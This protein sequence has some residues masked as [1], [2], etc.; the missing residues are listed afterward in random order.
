MALADLREFIDSPKLTLPIG[1]RSYNVGPVT[2]QV[3][4]R[5]QEIQARAAKVIEDAAKLSDDPDAVLAASDTEIDEISELDLIK[6]ALGDA[7]DVMVRGGVTGPE[8]KHAGVTAYY[9]QLGQESVAEA[10]WISAG[11][12]TAPRRAPRTS[13]RTSTGAATTTRKR[14]SGS[15]TS[16]RKKP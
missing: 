16:S 11:K 3:W 13:I 12:A 4:L 7:F 15:G 2:A 9:W 5:L 6:L 10:I 8:L 14:A 1:G